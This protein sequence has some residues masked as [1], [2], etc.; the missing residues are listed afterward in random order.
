MI[1]YLIELIF[2]IFWHL[3]GKREII[4]AHIC[5]LILVPKHIKFWL[6]TKNFVRVKYEF[7]V[8]QKQ[9]SFFFLFL[10]FFYKIEILL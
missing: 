5:W 2:A 6:Y 7:E 1:L 9:L 3:I 8:T 4:R 10:F